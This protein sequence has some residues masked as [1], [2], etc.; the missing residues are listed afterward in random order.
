MASRILHLAVAEQIIKQIPIKQKDRFRIGSILPDAYRNDCGNPEIPRSASHLKIFLC[1]N[2]KKTFDLGTY[3]S[4]FGKKMK[5]DE[6]YLGYYLH[7]IE[8]LIFREIVYD[9]YGWNSSIPGNI[10]RLHRD[11]RISNQ[12]VITKYELLNSLKEP[13]QF[14]EEEINTL[15]PFRLAEFIED[16]KSDFGEIDSTAESFFFTEAMA[17]EFV[18]TAT[19]ICIQEYD[20]IR[21]GKQ[22]TD[23]YEKAW[24]NKYRSLLET[25]ENTRELGGYRMQSGKLTKWNSLI[26][27]E[28]VGNPSEKDLQYLR[29]NNITT[30]IDLRSA[31]DVSN[32]TSGLWNKEGFTY[33]NLPV[34]EGSEMPA[35]VEAVPIS[36]M[37]IAGAKSMKA[38]Y[39]CIANAGSGILFHCTAGKDRTGVLSAILLMYVGVSDGDIIE[40][41]VLS[42]DY[43]KRRLEI[44]KERFPDKDAAIVTPCAYYM[45]DFLRLFREKYQNAENYLRNIGL[46]DENLIRISSKMCDE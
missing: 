23:Y 31:A 22:L 4:L 9:K 15:G 2:S 34:E 7:L 37:E 24:K 38:I 45:E 35:S 6:L 10:D 17:D 1:G 16:M 18:E 8:D 25:T 44:F 43:G 13:E 30:V 19:R 3:C 12:Y 5:E 41:Y 46:S 26:R 32:K 33:Y 42:K 36:Y 11:Y 29:S 27:S 14:I 28:L 39:Q 40:N 21:R 20:A